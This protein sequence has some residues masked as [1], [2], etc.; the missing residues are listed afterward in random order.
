MTYLSKHPDC[1]VYAGQDKGAQVAHSAPVE[2]SWPGQSYEYD[3][4]ALIAQSIPLGVPSVLY[5]HSSLDVEG[6]AG[7][8]DPFSLGEDLVRAGAASGSM[9]VPDHCGGM[10][11]D[12]AVIEGPM[13]MSP[14]E[15]S[16]VG[17]MFGFTPHLL[18]ACG[19][20]AIS[21]MDLD[22]GLNCEFQL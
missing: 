3:Q 14:P 20:E 21:D 9:S 6:F 18:G 11:I 2:R 13:S 22:L 19:L 15:E 7:F 4:D 8:N 1:E 16:D 12:Q 10:I 17:T 5:K